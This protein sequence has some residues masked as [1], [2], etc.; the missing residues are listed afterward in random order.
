MRDDT[1]LS[2]DVYVRAEPFP[3]LRAQIVQEANGEWEQGD[4]TDRFA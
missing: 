1:A 3:D 4:R 2:W